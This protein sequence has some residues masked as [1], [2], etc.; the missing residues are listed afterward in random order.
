[1]SRGIGNLASVQTDS[2]TTTS[3]TYDPQNRLTQMQTVCGASAT[4]CGPAGTVK[5]SYAYTLGPAGNRTKVVELS[6]RSVDYRYDDLYRLTSETIAGDARGQN[7]QVTYTLDNVG[8]RLQRNSTV[9]A[10]VATGL[11][12]YDPND[13]VSTD[14]FDANGN[15]I[16]NSGTTNVYDFENRLVRRGGVTILYDGDGNRVQESVAGATTRY[17]TAE[18]NPTG[19][20]QVMAELNG[21]NQLARGYLWGLQLAAMRTFVPGT[22]TATT[23]YFAFDGHGSVRYLTDDSGHITD[24]YDFDAF[25]NLLSSTGT[26]QNN[27]LFAGEQFDPALGIYYNRA[28]YYDQREGRFWTMDTYEGDP[29]S[30]ESL[31]KY[32]YVGA[33]PIDRVDPRGHDYNLS[34]LQT[35]GAAFTTLA[36]TALVSFQNVLG[37]IYVNLY[38]I[39]EV[40]ENANRTLTVGLGAF[41]ALRFLGSNILSYAEAY[42][43]GPVIRG[44]QFEEAAGANLSRTFPAIDYY[45]ADGGVAVQIR[46]TIQTQSPEALLAVVQRGVNRLNS[47]PETLVGRDR[48]G[49][50][51]AIEA[52]DIREKGLLVGIPAKPLPWFAT[53]L[54]RVR[55]LSESEN[56]SITI[57]F[58]EGLEGETLEK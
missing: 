10:V 1:M 34:S 22:F 7:G 31:H 27:Y 11:L 2:L 30:P 29:Q 8:N 54:E 42:S 13:R 47:L 4:G 33:N 44:D 21:S 48:A 23:A 24:T 9:P 39:P 18:L 5:A 35:A 50:P 55:E 53:F 25:G 36:T 57:Q 51:I 58:V 17:L 15:T 3:Y 14:I 41:E 20:V 19:Y 6:G 49:N 38:R 37:S 26:T 28:R 32:S 56:V 16:A 43:R 12:N 40:I 45:E 52:A 46:S